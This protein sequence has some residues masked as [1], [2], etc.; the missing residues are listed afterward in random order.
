[1]DLKN[2]AEQCLTSQRP[3]QDSFSVTLSPMMSAILGQSRNGGGVERFVLPYNQIPVHYHKLLGFP[4]GLR[5]ASTATTTTVSTIT[6][7]STGDILSPDSTNSIFQPEEDN[8]SQMSLS[9]DILLDRPLGDK[10]V[11]E[12]NLGTR[13]QRRMDEEEEETQDS[14]IADHQRDQTDDEEEGG[15][16]GEGGRQRLVKRPR[17]DSESQS[18]PPHFLHEESSNVSNISSTSNMELK[19]E[20]Q[21]RGG[22]RGERRRNKSQSNSPGGKAENSIDSLAEVVMN[23][24]TAANSETNFATV[25]GGGGGGGVAT[26]SALARL[27]SFSSIINGSPKMLTSPAAME[28]DGGSGT[29]P[30]CDQQ[31]LGGGNM[32]AGRAPPE[33]QQPNNLSP[34]SEGLLMN[35]E[36]PSGGGAPPL[37]VMLH[38]PTERGGQLHALNGA[39]TLVGGSAPASPHRLEYLSGTGR[40]DATGSAD[41]SGSSNSNNFQRRGSLDLNSTSVLSRRGENGKRPE[42]MEGLFND[43]PELHA[44]TGVEQA[45]TVEANQPDQAGFAFAQQGNGLAH[46][47]D[48]S[49]I[50]STAVAAA[51]PTIVTSPFQNACDNAVFNVTSSSIHYTAGISQSNSFLDVAPKRNQTCGGGDKAFLIGDSSGLGHIY[52]DSGRSSKVS[53]GKVLPSS[54][55]KRGRTMFSPD[56]DSHHQQGAT[57]HQERSAS[58]FLSKSPSSPLGLGSRRLPGEVAASPRLLQHHHQQQQQPHR[59]QEFNCSTH[60]TYSGELYHPIPSVSPV[61]EFDCGGKQRLRQTPPTS[62][63]PS[64]FNDLESVLGEEFAFHSALATNSVEN[65]PAKTPEKLLASVP[66]SVIMNSKKAGGASA[67]SPMGFDENFADFSGKAVGVPPSESVQHGNG[68]QKDD[69][70]ATFGVT[71]QNNIL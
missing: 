44:Q 71:C 38:H 37:K 28:V 56:P 20:E 53:P 61:K 18:S 57:N 34:S 40:L 31:N 22:G 17:L 33:Q 59:L 63:S 47:G 60:V 14:S 2:L 70:S 52:Q 50:V 23:I 29:D 65:V 11:L 67:S 25:G 49:C 12:E 4:T 54:I 32:A 26:D 6:S 51:M 13:Q 15:G 30:N 36:R 19:E 35:V 42:A 5:H 39:H 41:P 58:P 48:D 43:R 46:K 8:M 68:T 3:N 16:G 45:L 69:G 55:S 62:Q 66:P 10:V 7:V 1:M 21:Q 9:S 27:P 64:L 24:G